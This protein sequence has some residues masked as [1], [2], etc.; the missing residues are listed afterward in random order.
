MLVNAA[1]NLPGDPTPNPLL[2]CYDTVFC[3]FACVLCLLFPALRG[4]V[5]HQSVDRTAELGASPCRQAY[6]LAYPLERLGQPILF[7]E[8]EPFVN[9]RCTTS[10]RGS[11]L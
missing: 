3:I 8:A 1:P 2:L 7:P 10:G 6:E 9:P 5:V 4:H 11:R